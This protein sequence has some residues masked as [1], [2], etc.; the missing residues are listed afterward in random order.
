[1]PAQLETIGMAA[2]E[3]CETMKHVT[4]GDAVTYIEGYGFGSNYLLEDIRFSDALEEIRPSL[5]AESRALTQVH[6]PANLKRIDGY[7][8]YNSKSLKEIEFPSLLTEI[9]MEAFRY[10]ALE[11]VELPINLQI[12]GQEAF[13][14]NS[15]LKE[16]VMPSFIE[17]GN[18]TRPYWRGGSYGWWSDS[19]P[20][21]YR[22]NFNRCV[23]IE[24]VTMRA[25]TP[26][27]VP[28]DPF[29]N[30]RDKSVITLV[31][32]SFAVVNYKLDTYWKAFGSI[33][34]GDDVDYWKITSPLMLT[35]NRRMQGTPDV[36]LY[37]NGQ[38]TVGGSAPMTMDKFNMFFSEDNPGRLLNTCDAV[39]ANEAATKFS[40]VANR[41]YFITPVHDVNVAD[42]NVSNDA[43]Y[44]FRY[45]DAE[46]R[47]VKGATG[48]WKNV[49]TSVLKGGQGYIFHCN[50]EC[51]ITFPADAAGQAQL[52]TTADVTWNLTTNESTTAANRSWNYV[53]NPYPCYYDIFYMDFTA[54]ITIWNGS[55]Y[56]AYSIADDDLVLRPMQS[57]FVQK[58]DAVDKIVFKK[59]GRQLLSTVAAHTT[60]N[61]YATGEKARKIF[62]IQIIDNETEASDETRVVLNNNANM[63][64]ELE[65]DASK[66]MSFDASVPQI[67]TTDGDGNAYA[68]NERPTLNGMVPLA[69]YATKDG[70]Y[71]INVLRAD[72]KVKLQDSVEGKT[73]DITSGTY[74]FDAEA[75]NEANTSRFT[76]VFNEAT[77]INDVNEND[78]VNGNTFDLMGRMTDAT[79]PGIYIKDN[80]KIVK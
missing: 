33:V 41:W 4:M 64:Y 79:Q 65:C 32:P 3:Y 10:S 6:L 60:G 28:A 2:F 12:L 71:T 20:S 24:K 13:S 68:I 11:K 15:N 51:I 44:V 42:I 61:S 8:F 14:D 18:Y 69:F 36:D 7:A 66:F 56:K 9:H 27:T 39:T 23:N 1:M 75:S 38:L 21:G 49:D 46:N 45:Y 34:E 47:A 22:N 78:N 31:V 26:P 16:I 70:K 43:S 80:V 76:L 37:Y 59:E 30:S 40:V 17:S 35:N 55:T 29:T 54:P 74:T 57:F 63:G 52:F 58:P 50:K 19:Q 48:S 62:N 5:C 73:V 25:A 77:G 72:G 67:F 53:G